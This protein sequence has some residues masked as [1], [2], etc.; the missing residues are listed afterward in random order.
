MQGVKTISDVLN[1]LAKKL[2]V[3]RGTLYVVDEITGTLWDDDK[4]VEGLK[5]P[6][7]LMIALD[8]NRMKLTLHGHNADNEDDIDDDDDDDYD[9]WS[10]REGSYFERHCKHFEGNFSILFG[11][12]KQNSVVFDNNK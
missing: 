5:E 1:I 6:L 8:E 9:N 3:I 12:P 7:N 10:M 11:I 2:D 4:D